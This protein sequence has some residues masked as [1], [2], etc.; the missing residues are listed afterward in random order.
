MIHGSRVS[1]GCLAMTDAKI[2]EI[3]TLCAAAHEG[4]QP[5]FRVHMFPFRMTEARMNQASGNKWE[6]FWKNLREGYDWF[7]THHTPPEVTVGDK[8]YKFS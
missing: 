8:R 2:E 1:I 5:Y 7:E 6:D 4:G 3:Y